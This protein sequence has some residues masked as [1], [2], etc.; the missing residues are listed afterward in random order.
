[1]HAVQTDVVFPISAKFDKNFT[2]SDKKSLADAIVAKFM[3]REEEIT[4]II[5]KSKGWGWVITNGEMVKA[6]AWLLSYGLE[7]SYEGA[8]ALTALWKAKNQG[9]EFKNPV[10][11]LTG[12]YY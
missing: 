7:C 9:Y 1:M 10:C 4:E 8:A 3:P 11:I 5:H 2:K 6:R 12:K